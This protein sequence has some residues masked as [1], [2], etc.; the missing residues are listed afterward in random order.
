MATPA[1]VLSR[2]QLH[3][4]R[5]QELTRVVRRAPHGRTKRALKL[6]SE[7]W[8]R[9]PSGSAG[10]SSSPSLLSSAGQ[11]APLGNPNNA[12]THTHRRAGK[13]NISAVPLAALA[14]GLT[15]VIA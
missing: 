14:T 9:R 5:P 11:Q 10:D 1:T 4:S 6:A 13:F 8:S 15:V 3:L 7:L 12:T 2:L